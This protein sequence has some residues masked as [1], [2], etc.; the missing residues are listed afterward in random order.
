MSLPGF[1]HDFAFAFLQVGGDGIGD[2]LRVID[3]EIRQL[4]RD[5]Q[6]VFLVETRRDF[7][8]GHIVET[9]L[10]FFHGALVEHFRR[11]GLGREVNA[12]V[13]G[14]VQHGGEQAHFK[15]ERQHV[16]ARRPALAAFR[17][18]FLHEQ[19]P[20][21]QVDRADDHQMPAKDGFELQHGEDGDV[22]LI[23]HV[24]RLR[25]ATLR[26]H[27]V[28]LTGRSEKALR[29]R[30]L[31][32]TDRDYL[33]PLSRFFQK[34]VFVL[35]REAIPVLLEA[36]LASDAIARRRVR[37]RELKPMTIAHLLFVSDILT[38]L[39]IEERTSRIKIIDCQHDGPLL[40]DHATAHDGHGNEITLPVRPD[41]KLAL[42]DTA[43]PEGRNVADVFVE[44]D[45][46][47]M[48]GERM[49]QKMRAYLAYYKQQRYAQ[50]YPGMKMFQV[51]TVTETRSRAEYLAQHLAGVLPT[52]PA[53]RAYHFIPFEDLTLETLFP[54]RAEIA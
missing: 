49:E 20:H 9:H 46:G 41:L 53:R 17:D 19:P 18:D 32:L 13:L 10:A 23:H 25:A 22:A 42:K 38:K 44:A 43:R 11:N 40:W 29:A 52:G 12:L 30:I 48:S 15:L 4:H 31:K 27:L 28:P 35:G 24:H 2:A 47:T 21:R 34:N 39:F 16:H 5:G 37:D 54:P 3:R 6:F 7:D 1:A 33:A 26:D 36:G 51:L 14:L 50:K 45:R 8:V